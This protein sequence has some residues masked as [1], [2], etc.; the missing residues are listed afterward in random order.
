MEKKFKKTTSS[1]VAWVVNHGFA[2]VTLKGQKQILK[3]SGPPI[4]NNNLTLY[5][6]HTYT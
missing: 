5:T 4:K 3:L 2:M 6:N 1:I